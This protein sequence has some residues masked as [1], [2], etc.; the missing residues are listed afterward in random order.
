MIDL[1]KIVNNWLLSL[2]NELE[3]YPSVFK[4]AE[5]LCGNNK[6]KEAYMLINNFMSENELKQSDSYKEKDTDFFYGIH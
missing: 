4:K 2:K 1:D 5:D 6:Y 3:E